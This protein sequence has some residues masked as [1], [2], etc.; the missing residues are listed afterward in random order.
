VDKGGLLR[1]LKDEKMAEELYG[2]DWTKQVEDINE[3]FYSSYKFGAPLEKASE[4][5]KAELR[6]LAH[7]I[8]AD[9]NI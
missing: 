5:N 9:K 1:K 8:S 7:S 6:V 4:Y 2:V 3:A